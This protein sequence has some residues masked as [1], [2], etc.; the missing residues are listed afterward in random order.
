MKV[1]VLKM[2]IIS[3]KNLSKT[4]TIIEKESGI[5]GSLK[6]LLKPKKKYITAL[7]DISFNIEQG[8]IV[9]YIGP[10]GAGKSTTIKILL[11]ILTPTSGEV[12]IDGLSPVDNR[13][14]VVQTIGVVFGQRSNLI[15]DIRLNESFELYKRM[16]QIE[17]GTYRRKKQQLIELLGL[18][19]FIDI[20]VRQ[21]SL[22][23][24]MRGEIASALLHSPGLLFLDEPTI[25]L[26][27]A[28]R[29]NILD[30]IKAVN[31]ESN[32][33]VILTSHNLVDIER[34]CGRV[35]MINSGRLVENN[36]IAYITN[37]VAPYKLLMIEYED[38]EQDIDIPHCQLCRREGNKVWYKFDRNL[39]EVKSLMREI[40]DHY[41]IS[42]IKIEDPELEDVIQRVFAQWMGAECQ[43]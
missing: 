43:F 18:G 17:E 14:K 27:F 24:R 1:Q 22:G 12:L 21:L 41:A 4:Y 9:G 2:S 8:E 15:W 29:K 16:Y 7:D 26:D 37:K 23:Q 33:T 25:G 19:E 30:Y 3:V 11:G 39:I 5:A 20:P 10:N 6:S 42:D 32:V 34:T 28:S 40:I 13:I 31:E 38:G 36:S 35:I